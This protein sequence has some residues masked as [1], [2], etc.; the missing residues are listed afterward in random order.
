MA[1]IVFDVVDMT[2]NVNW[3]LLPLPVNAA[4]LTPAEVKL[5]A[6]TAVPLTGAERNVNVVL[7]K[8]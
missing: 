6:W 8:V 2:G 1:T 4:D 5:I 3:V 7:D